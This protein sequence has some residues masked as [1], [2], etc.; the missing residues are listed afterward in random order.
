MKES[1][2]KPKCLK[3][4]L[5]ERIESEHVC[6]R[7]RF[8]F[9]GRECFVWFLWLLSVVVGAFAVAVSLFVVTHQQYALYEATHE[10]VFTYL[11]EVLPYL[12]MVIFGLMV[13]IALYNLRHTAHGYRHPVWMV[14]ASSV[15]LSFAGGTAL[16]MFG[17]GYSVD[18]ILGQHMQAYLSQGKLEHKLWQDPAEGRMVGR[19]VLSTVSPTTTV[20]FED[21]TGHRWRMDVTELHPRDVALLASGEKVR[22]MGKAI[23]EEVSLFH[24]CGSFPLL[25]ERDVTMERMSAERDEFLARIRNHAEKRELTLGFTS[26][27]PFASTTLPKQSQCATI[28]A[29]RRLS[30]Q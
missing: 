12:W 25:L 7:S 16:H 20:I 8:F 10:N 1:P 30:V 26:D 27:S 21:I 24:A 2:K 3:T 13:Y 22:L 14:L 5:F 29:V 18:N 11:V 17:I 28:P 23:N 15:V 4:S 6:P 19:Q 9:R